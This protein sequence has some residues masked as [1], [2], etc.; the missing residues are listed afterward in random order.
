MRILMLAQFYAPITGGEERHVQDLSRAL[1][2]GGHDVAVATLAC[3]GCPDFEI[4]HGVRVYRLQ[5]TLQRATWLFSESRRRHVPPLPDPELVWG[6]RRVVA[7]ERPDIVHAHNWLV[8][9]FLPLKRWSGAKLIVTLHDYSLRCAEKHLMYRDEQLC[10]GPGLTKCFNCTWQHYGPLKG[11]VTLLGNQ[12]MGA[13]ERLATDLYLAVS[14]ATA[15]G[16]GLTDDQAALEVIPNF[17][18]DQAA[19]Q[20]IDCE[21]YLAQLPPDGFLLFVGDLSREKGIEVLLAAY[22]YLKDA[23]PLVLI[24]RR[25]PDTPQ[26]L[27]GHVVALGNWPHQAVMEAWRRC[28]IAVVPSTLAEPFGIV[29][30][31]AMSCGR[32]VIASDIGGLRDIVAHE[33]TG[34]R[35][36]PGD[37]VA[38]QQ[39]LA[40]LLAEPD[41]GRRLGEAGR[42]RVAAFSVSAVVPRIE[43]AYQTVLGD[44]VKRLE[45][46]ARPER[47]MEYY[48]RSEA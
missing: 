45:N 10:S 25:L 39:A 3:E 33:E 11:S 36:A 9:Q 16:N 32:P 8:Y 41:L 15:A 6:L 7:R 22:A 28:Q 21:A 40:R 46:G 31:E 13:L 24:G 23:P 19:G 34:L 44:K 37:A 48:D 18:P 5:G 29:A 4:D 20:P 27:P 17:V 43:Q 12:A 42:Q 38:L 1:A 2:A 35:V 30:I 47:Q 26:V 14:E